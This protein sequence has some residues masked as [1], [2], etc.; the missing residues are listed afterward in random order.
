M[1]L[2]AFVLTETRAAEPVLP[3]WVFTRRLLG[4][5]ALIG[6][7]VGVILMGVTTYVPTYL[8]A[9]LHVSPLTSGL[10]LAA[11]TLGW[12]ITASQAGRVYLR[13]GFR[14]TVLI[15]AVVTVLAAGAWR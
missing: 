15:G 8:E 14:A 13:F 3:L 2:G 11:L 6:V 10:A 7:G 1:L 12:P 4:T 9:T 5:T